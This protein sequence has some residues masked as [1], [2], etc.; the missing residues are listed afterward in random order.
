MEKI[1]LLLIDDHAVVRT[2]YR[3]LLESQPDL[4]VIGEADS[5]KA[6]LALRKKISPDV[7]VLDL[8][9]PDIGGIEL[10]QRFLRTDPEVLILVFSMHKDPIFI[11]QAIRAGAMGYV[12]KSSPAEIML[13]AVYKVANRQQYISPDISSE[14]AITLL[15]EP[16]NPV[17]DLSPREFQILQMFLDGMDAQSIANSLSISNKTV[18]NYHYQ[19]KLKLNVKNDI[20]LARIGFKYGLI[21]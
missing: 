7:I 1:S 21:S 6:A 18:H 16:I 15:K 19:I 14:L 5:A 11:T 12:T 13:E 9:L 8:G 20:D 3:R 17:A 4:V 2:G 10:L